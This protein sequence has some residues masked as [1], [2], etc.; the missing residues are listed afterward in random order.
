MTPEIIDD[1]N[2][3]P[4]TSISQLTAEAKADYQHDWSAYTFRAKEYKDYQTNL[5]ELIIWTLSTLSTTLCKTCCLENTT[6]DQWYIA[7]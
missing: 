1:T 6:V 2:H 3:L 5:K 7:L 4:I